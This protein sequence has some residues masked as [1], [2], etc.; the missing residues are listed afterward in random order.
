MLPQY[1]RPI[2]FLLLAFLAGFSERW[3]PGTL[4]TI[5]G[6][7]LQH[8]SEEKKPTATERLHNPSSFIIDQEEHMKALLD[9]FRKPLVQASIIGAIGGITPKLIEILP[10]LFKN[11]FPPHGYLYGLIILAFIGAVIIVVY[12]EENFQKA[13]I[14][15]AGAPALIATLTAQAV[16]PTKQTAALVSPFQFSFTAEAFAQE[17]PRTDTVHIVVGKNESPYKLNSLWIRAGEQT[18]QYKNKGDTVTVVYPTDA[19]EI[20]IDL[21]EQGESLVLPRTTQ[22]NKTVEV[23]ISNDADRKGFWKAFGGAD[24]P[25]Y[26]IEEKK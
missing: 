5:I 10:Q 13:F 3:L 1:P 6:E 2:L 23:K 16:A 24:V 7:K 11:T 8:A 20:K 26:R 19:Q 18:L 4:N 15:G 12:K 17:Q 25:Q 9:F 14:L 21:P 22:R